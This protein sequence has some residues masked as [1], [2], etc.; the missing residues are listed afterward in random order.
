MP[1]EVKKVMTYSQSFEEVY[2]AAY[3]SIQ[4]LKGKVVKHDLANKQLF[5][6]MDKKFKGEVL[7][8]RSQLEMTF[9]QDAGGK[10]VVSMYA[11]PLN[12]VGQKLMFGARKGVVETVVA[13]FFEEVAQKLEGKGA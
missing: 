13:G 1:F 9:S 4:S 7:G 12:A 2:K 5:G 3:L 8:D 11:Y 10:T 6:Q